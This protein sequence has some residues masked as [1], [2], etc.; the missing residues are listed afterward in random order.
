MN[1]T[2]NYTIGYQTEIHPIKQFSNYSDLKF[3]ILNVKFNFKC[4]QKDCNADS[5]LDIT[6]KLFG[7]KRL[8]AVV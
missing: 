7:K 2:V 4:R 5:F 1:I 3:R 6:L 8:K